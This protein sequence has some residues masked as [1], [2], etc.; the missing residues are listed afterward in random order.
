MDVK[1]KI[2]GDF[3]EKIAARYLKKRG[4]KILK[5]N[6]KTAHGEID[7]ICENQDFLVFVEVK[8]RKDVAENFEDY[9]LPRTAVTRKKQE[10]IVYSARQFLERFE[11]EKEIRFDVIEVYLGRTPRVCHIESA[12]HL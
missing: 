12:F 2:I 11:A 7:I 1:T 4:Y 9:G 10:H 6:Y 3:G 8:S 5:R